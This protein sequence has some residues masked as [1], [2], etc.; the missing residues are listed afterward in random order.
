MGRIVVS[1]QLARIA[2]AM[3]AIVLVLFTLDQ[4]D[5]PQLAGIV[6]F[7]STAPGIVLS[8][9]AGALLDRYQ[10]MRLIRLDYAIALVTMLLIAGL[11][12]AGSLSPVALVL[13]AAVSSIT[14][15]LSQT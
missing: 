9:I 1:M 10:R 5:S 13:I 2:Q 15:P 11:S 4:F 7:A 14:N 6:T 3:V 12:L 8:P